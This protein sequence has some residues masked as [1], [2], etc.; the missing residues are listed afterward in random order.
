MPK[1]LTLRTKFLYKPYEQYFYDIENNDSKYT[2]DILL[3]KE[4]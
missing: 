2:L 4:N 3:L 1:P